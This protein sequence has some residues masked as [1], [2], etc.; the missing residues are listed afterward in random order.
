V[1]LSGDGGDEVFGGYPGYVTLK[2]IDLFLNISRIFPWN[3]LKTLCDRVIGT[4]PRTSIGRTICEAL[5]LLS[6]PKRELRTK[7]VER[8]TKSLFSNLF[9]S[10][11]LQPLK[12]CNM[13]KIYSDM[14]D[15]SQSKNLVDAGLYSAL[16][17]I[18]QHGVIVLPDACGMANSI[19]IRAPYLDDKIVDFAASL[20]V[21][22]KVKSLFTSKYNKYII[23][24]SFSRI[25]P[26]RILYR[27]KIG[28]GESI[29]INDWCKTEWKEYISNMIFTGSISK[30][31]IFNVDYIKKIWDEHISGEKDHIQLIWSLLI[32]E[33]WYQ[34]FIEK[35]DP[36][37]IRYHY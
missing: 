7:I 25:L 9:N 17:F 19:E 4:N 1:V 24:K 18:D 30:S 27:E 21:N 8:A 15:E 22:Q 2:R 3:L 14:Y 37:I 36:D 10:D 20:P 31:G 35:T 26:E 34:L 28:F 23:K 11:F 16:L 5:E 29:P 33:V 13:G 32:F 12:D 6:L